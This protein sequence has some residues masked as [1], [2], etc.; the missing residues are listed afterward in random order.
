[1][2][3]PWYESTLVWG[4]VGVGVGIVVTVVAALTKD[5]RWLL[6]IAWPIFSVAFWLIFNSSIGPRR[7]MWLLT[8]GACV[9]TGGAL[10]WLSNA[11]A[12]APH[13]DAA[14]S[15]AATE[16]AKY[17][18]GIR[19]T[20]VF[21]GKGPLAVY[22][23]GY[24]SFHGST[25]SPVMALTNILIHS[26][27][28]EPNTI[29]SYR[30]AVGKTANGPWV[31]LVPI[32]LQGTALY[33]LGLKTVPSPKDAI[34]GKGAYILGAPHLTT[35]DMKIAAL[36]QPY[37]TFESQLS[38]PIQPHSTIGGWA[39]FDVRDR[40]DDAMG[41]FYKVTLRDSANVITAS[42]Y[43]LPARKPGDDAEQ[44]TQQGR[45]VVTGAVSDI[46]KFHIRYFGGDARSVTK[47]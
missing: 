45:L 29:E 43:P 23:V 44:D 40:N 38:R 14:P 17:T 1:M 39:A 28:N 13:A 12:P 41:N 20:Q 9:L 37:P 3:L 33:M 36:L 19:S 25:V 16:S 2:L 32:P 18:V 8:V 6:L 26:N 42:V 24:N 21:T 31:D 11:L 22:M 10:D 35:D 5:P 27:S 7:A 4:L 34:I 46:S 30:V 15:S 47:K